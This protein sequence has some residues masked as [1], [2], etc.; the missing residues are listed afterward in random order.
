MKAK[1][2]ITR[3]LATFALE[4]AIE[5][6]SGS[7]HDRRRVGVAQCL[8]NFYD[9]INYEG[10]FLSEKAQTELPEIGRTLCVLY[11]QLS[12]EASG[13]AV[14]LWKCSP[15]HHLCLHLCKWQALESGNPR[16]Y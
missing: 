15:K 11:G 1:A 3:H 7:P 16:F 14:R 2:A 9:I 13:E 4:L 10:M 8:V 12:K 5:H 6:D